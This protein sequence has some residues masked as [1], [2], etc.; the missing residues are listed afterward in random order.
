ME[1]LLPA[2]DAVTFGP[3]EARLAASIYAKVKHPRGREIDIAIAACALNGNATLW[4][5]NPDD[6]KDIPGLKTL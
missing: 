1:D 6:F 2:A 3:D 4:T 5:L